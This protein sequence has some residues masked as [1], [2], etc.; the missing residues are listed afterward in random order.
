MKNLYL[1]IALIS[2]LLF[3]NKVKS[4]N[5]IAP[6][7]TFTNTGT[8]AT[9]PPSTLNDLNFGTCG[10]QQMWMSTSSPPSATPGVDWIQVDFPSTHTINEIIIHH[11][12]ISGRFLSG[13]I[14]QRW[15]GG[16]WVNHFTFTNLTPACSTSIVFP[17][18]TTSRFRLTAFEM[19]TGGQ[20]SN[21]NFRE[22][23]IIDVPEIPNDARPISFDAPGQA[24][25]N[26]LK[27]VEVSIENPGLNP[28]NSVKINWQIIRSG[29]A[30]PL[31]SYNWTGNLLN[32]AA[33]NNIAV[34]SFPPGFERG[35]IFK[36]WT[37]SPN[38]VP[39]SSA[40]TDTLELLIR[41]GVS[42][43]YNVGG[44]FSIDFAS[45]GQVEN[46]VDSFGAVCDSLIFNFRDGVYEGNLNI[47]EVFN[48]TPTRP[49]IFR[50]ENGTNSNVVFIDSSISSGSYLN[51]NNPK[52]I[53]FENIVFQNLSSGAQRVISINGV[54]DNVNFSGCS[55]ENNYSGTNTS[56]NFNLISSVQKVFGSG[57]HF[58]D[59]N[60]IGG[61]Y[62]VH[63]PGIN[64][65]SLLT[66]L[67]I[68]SSSFQNQTLGSVNLRFVENT[69][70]KSSSFSSN[71]TLSNSS[72][73]IS[74]R[75]NFGLMQLHSNMIGSASGWPSIGVELD[76]CNGFPS[77]AGEVFNNMISVGSVNSPNV[78]GLIAKN[79]A[80]VNYLYNSISVNASSSTSK[81]IMLD[82]GGANRVV[83]NILANFAGG[84]TLD[85]QESSGFP[86]F[87]SNYNNFY[88]SGGS[89][90]KH[91][92]NVYST[93]ALW[94]GAIGDDANSISTNPNFVS[95]IDLHVCSPMMNNMAKPLSAVL[96]DLDGQTRSAVKPDMGADEYSPSNALDLGKDTVVCKGTE[97]A[98]DGSLNNNDFYNAWSTGD[99]S[100][101]LII[102]KPG[103]YSVISSNICGT[104]SDTIEIGLSPPASLGVDTNIC[105]N[106]S[107]VLDANVA[108]ASYA[109]NTG[110]V[111][112]TKSISG[113]GIYS[114]TVIDNNA[115]V[116]T[117][118]IFVTQSQE[119]N[120]PSDTSL[121][122]GKSV[123]LNPNTGPGTYAWNNGQTSPLILAN[124]SG[125]FSVTYTDLF[126]CTS[127]GATD[128]IITTAPDANFTDT[129]I[130][131]AVS[132]FGKL[133]PNA[134]YSWDFGDG[135]TSLQQNPTH[136][137][138]SP[139]VY[140]ATLQIT[141][142]CG[143]DF[144]SKELTVILPS[145]GD[146]EV[147]RGLNI[148][149]NPSSGKV[150]LNLKEKTNF[151]VEI[152]DLAGKLVFNN[153]FNYLGQLQIDLEHLNS[154]V[155]QIKVF[156]ENLNY[157][158]K[159]IIQ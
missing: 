101:V 23:E 138:K 90:T 6:L 24:I 124:T 106:S 37:E 136:L 97:L 72:K 41:E 80:F 54:L 158:E 50:G 18:M 107:L 116:T 122:G 55:F 94:S 114:V 81:A 93:L 21:P 128:V 40:E 10:T 5:N 95:A 7:G 20:T 79:C 157:Q 49:V 154:G 139:G 33:A 142:D 34:G 71:S 91:K 147:S 25:C 105:A 61:N 70:I 148:F 85:Y 60:F 53:F 62:G 76:E 92:T 127:S 119:V 141:N 109:W 8:Q 66:N 133:Y 99:S 156:N 9:F 87:E 153:Q 146:L 98:L 144:Y 26:N 58:Y 125:N 57:L 27:N 103:I 159:L 137:Y 118:T 68:V 38:G 51:L 44:I 104:D 48:T 47:N 131:Y 113:S 4:Q 64:E 117:D 78:T 88:S 30:F 140:V 36:C 3:F 120:L 16:S 126:G 155:Y 111:T 89:L 84:L 129:T 115:C 11:G 22:M 19:T 43:E 63:F 152:F 77:K 75:N 42:G 145:A 69:E 73:A 12:Q 32:G 31:N 130:G 132:F 56:Q 108:N 59:C 83:N 134:S 52:N 149:P 96:F 102:S 143:A 151:N 74:I 15:N 13:A 110:E 45:I 46:F 35:D 86:V 82:G 65:D 29:T 100:T 1:F 123:F 39:D 17:K 135:D 121:C 112:K 14:I 67:T 28:L 150:F 2:T